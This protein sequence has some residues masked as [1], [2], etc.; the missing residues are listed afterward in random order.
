MRRFTA[1]TASDIH[2][3]AKP[4][5]FEFGERESSSVESELTAA[6]EY[7]HIVGHFLLQRGENSCQLFAMVVA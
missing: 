7:V 2:E 3:L 5:K 6:I 1:K 4:T